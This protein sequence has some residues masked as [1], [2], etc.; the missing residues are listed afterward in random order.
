MPSAY[1]DL[2]AL[3]PRSGPGI[4]G[5][6]GDLFKD[7]VFGRD[8]AEVADAL[9]H[10]DPALARGV[11][12]SL[13]SLQGVVDAPPGPHSNEEERGKIHHEHRSLYVDGRRVSPRVQQLM[14]SLAVRW[15][16]D[17]ESLTYYGAV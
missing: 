17:E 6:G 11:I 15:G 8:S 10:L 2:A 14:E 9:A 12:E 1:A 13:V 7:A 5:S 3:R 16:G 4:Y